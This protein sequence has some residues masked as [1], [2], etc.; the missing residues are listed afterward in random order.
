MKNI[1]NVFAVSIL[2]FFTQCGPTTQD[3]VDYNE[4]VITDQLLVIDAIN[5]LD[6]TFI[7]YNPK[8]IEPALNNANLQV[9]KAISNLKEFGVFN[10]DSGF[11]NGT[12]ALYNLFEKQLNNEY[13]EQFEIYKLSEE[14]YT[15]AKRIR[16]NELL[17]KINDDYA[18]I[19][20]KFLVAQ[21][22]FAK[23][24][25]LELKTY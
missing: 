18:L 12:M 20:D 10:N 1:I 4:K 23:K 22:D 17:E 5:N 21:K 13:L 25:N 11:Y 2:L 9:E 7:S 24:W 16:Y 19:S 14:D 15:E 8:L 3:A 6:S